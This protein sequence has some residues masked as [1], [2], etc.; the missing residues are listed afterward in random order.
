[1]RRFLSAT[2]LATVLATALVSGA[3]A[4]AQH[5]QNPGFNYG[6]RGYSPAWGY[7]YDATRGASPFAGAS[8]YGNSAPFQGNFQWAPGFGYGRAYGNYGHPG[9]NRYVGPSW[10]FPEAWGYGW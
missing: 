9:F 2:A 8:R 10:A 6:T 1:M 5:Y 7:G 4:S 3:T